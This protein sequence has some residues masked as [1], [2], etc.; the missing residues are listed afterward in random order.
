MKNPDWPSWLTGGISEDSLMNLRMPTAALAT[1]EFRSC[2]A[3]AYQ[4]GTANVHFSRPEQRI[5]LALRR[6]IS[7]YLCMGWTARG[8]PACAVNNAP[9]VPP[10]ASGQPFRA[11]RR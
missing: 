10:H 6:A 11:R 8:F 5:L 4:T 9:T 1:A 7:G 3:T 2:L